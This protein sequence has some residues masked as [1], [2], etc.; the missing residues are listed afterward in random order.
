MLTPF[1]NSA[2]SLM[3]GSRPHF[4]IIIVAASVGWISLFASSLNGERPNILRT[5]CNRCQSSNCVH[6]QNATSAGEWHWMRSP[7]QER[8]VVV[9][10]YNR[11]CVRCHGVDGK[12]VYDIP[13]VPDFTNA[14]WQQCRSDAQLVRL[15]IEGRGACMPAFRGTLS[16]E[17][18]WAMARYLRTF[19][20][21][22]AKEGVTTPAPQDAK[23]NDKE[24]DNA[25]ETEEE[26][27]KKSSRR[28]DTLRLNGTI[29]G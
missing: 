2:C 12:G 29:A 17:E 14:R 25:E 15:T 6:C 19:A 24:R 20:A 9:A 27:Q 23:E 4:R 21:V 10:Q 26:Q 3:G 11:Y 13:D 7:D 5:K 16:V 18:T 28:K 1:V 22:P 8:R